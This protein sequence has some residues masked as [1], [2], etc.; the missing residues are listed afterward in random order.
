MCSINFLFPFVKKKKL[1]YNF[2]IDFYARLDEK[3]RVVTEII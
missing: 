1:W 2:R 3:G